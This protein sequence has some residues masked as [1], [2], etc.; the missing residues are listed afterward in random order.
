MPLEVPGRH[1]RKRGAVIVIDG[2]LVEE[3]LG[4]RADL[5]R[6]QVLKATTRA[7]W[8]IIPVWSARRPK[9]RFRSA[10][11]S[12]DPAPLSGFP[13]SMPTIDPGDRPD[14]SC[15]MYQNRLPAE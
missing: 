9:S 13:P 1:A 2:L 15:K 14:G 3:D 10:R 6:V 12:I 11:A 5:S 7:A 8:S 4:Q